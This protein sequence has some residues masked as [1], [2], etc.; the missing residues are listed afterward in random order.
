MPGIRIGPYGISFYEYDLREPAHV[1]VR[2]EWK[3]AKFW[4]APV[5]LARNNGF[6]AHELSAIEGLLWEN[7]GKLLALWNGERNKL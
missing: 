6:P 5:A 7:Q 3:Q 2:R 4:L 1:H